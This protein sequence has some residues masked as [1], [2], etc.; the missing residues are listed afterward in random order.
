MTLVSKELPSDLSKVLGEWALAAGRLL[1]SKQTG[2][3]HA[4]Y[5]DSQQ[6]IHT[7]PLVENVL[8]ALALLRSRLVEQVQEA[9]LILKGLLAFQN[10]YQNDSYGNFPV[11]LHEYPVCKDPAT[12]LHLLAPFYWILKQ[13][14]HVL[15]ADLKIQLEQ[16]VRLILNQSLLIHQ[17]KPFPYSLAVRLAAAQFAFGSLWENLEWQQQGKKQLEGELASR[18]LEGWYTTAHLGDLLVG[19]QMVYPSLKNSPWQDLWHRMEQTWHV[20]T[21]CYIG[22]CV[23]EWQGREEPRPN[24]Y[25]LYGG[26]FAGQFARRTT[27]LHPYHLHGALI[28]S[29]S[30]KFDIHLTNSSIEGQLKQQQWKTVRSSD[31]AYTVLEKKEPYHPSMDKTFTPFR[32]IWGNIHQVHSLVCQ[33]G[34]FERVNYKMQDHSIELI[35]DLID[36]QATEDRPQR[37]IEFFVDFHPDFLFKLNQHSANTF[38]LGQCL[39]FAFGNYQLSFVFEL[40]EGEGHFLGHIMRGNRPSQTAHRGEKSFHAYDWTF[41]LR[42]IRRQGH[43]RLKANLSFQT[44]KDSQA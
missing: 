43:C 39:K 11:Y 3:V 34:I 15:G 1:Q 25:D 26:Y 7:I 14:G 32:L 30:D 20:Q 33:G 24:L 10:L 28:Q 12:G 23:R 9:K 2:Y 16:A 18:Q 36:H 31:W 41:F 22:P 5:E 38:E 42:T 19:L 4:Y 40:I 44:L 21:G 6:E 35:Y 17:I 29:S 13:F 27:L 37:E 8:F